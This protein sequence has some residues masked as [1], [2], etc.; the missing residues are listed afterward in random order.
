MLM[1]PMFGEHD[2]VA[3]FYCASRAGASASQH[4]AAGGIDHNDAVRH[5]LEKFC[6]DQL[7]IA[8]GF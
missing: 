4:D 6:L 5:E 2:Q 7:G 1:A 8:L 3:T